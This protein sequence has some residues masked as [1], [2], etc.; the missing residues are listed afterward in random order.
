MKILFAADMPFNYFDGFPGKENAYLA[1]QEAAERFRQADFS[2][3]NLENVLGDRENGT[4]M[5]NRSFTVWATFSS[6]TKRIKKSHGIMD[7]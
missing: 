3:I 7:I 6:R 4:P 2:M 1:M 5:V